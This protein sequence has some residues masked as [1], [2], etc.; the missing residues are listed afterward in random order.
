MIL[1]TWRMGNQSGE[2]ERPDE[3]LQ[4]WM[5]RANAKF[6]E[7]PDRMLDGPY[8]TDTSSTGNASGSGSTTT[9]K[10]RRKK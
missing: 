5:D 10:P 8:M 1:V 6:S 4:M 2:R 3:E 7:N 9:R